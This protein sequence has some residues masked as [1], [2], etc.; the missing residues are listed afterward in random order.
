[1]VNTIFQIRATGRVKVGW[2]RELTFWVGHKYYEYLI[3]WA[4]IRMVCLEV[5]FDILF[6]NLY[7]ICYIKI[8]WLKKSLRQQIQYKGELFLTGKNWDEKKISIL[9]LS[10]YYTKMNDPKIHQCRKKHQFLE[11]CKES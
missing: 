5:F 3:I 7:T 8:L 11:N 10:T 2:G 6:F 9:F 1:M 4:V